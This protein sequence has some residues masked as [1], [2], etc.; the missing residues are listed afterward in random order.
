MGTPQEAAEEVSKKK[1]ITFL[2]Q[3]TWS[4]AGLWDVGEATSASLHC[5][6]WSWIGL[7]SL[8][9]LFPLPT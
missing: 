2:S 4:L 1:K 7:G 3:L 5:T 9:Y 6:G 8:P